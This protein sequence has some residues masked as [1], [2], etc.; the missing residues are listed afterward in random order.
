MSLPPD[1][2]HWEH[3]QDMI[4]REHNKGV[5]RY[6]KDLGDATWEPSVNT[7]R[8]AIRT[9]CTVD[10]KDTVI[11]TLLRLYLFYDI[12]G[13]GKK[14]LGRV[15]GVPDHRIEEDVAG[16][17]QVFLYFSQDK[18]SVP[19]GEKFTDAEYSFRLMNETSSSMTEN[20]AKAIAR[21]IKQE[22]IVS[23]KGWSFTKGKYI[24]NYKDPSLGYRLGIRASNALEGEGV[25][26]KILSIQNHAFD[27]NKLTINEPKK[28]SQNNPTQTKLIYG[29]QKKVNRWRP[30][31]NVR[32][33]YAYMYVH[34]LD[35]VVYLADTTGNFIDVLED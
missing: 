17:P 13:Y 22:F 6:F 11:Q 35:N 10:D 23:N 25:I 2:G 15:F 28:N 19:D 9:A 12:L 31:A 29:Q 1:F 7:P 21:Q 4:R 26:R 5:A 34:G 30:T 33:R 16:K 24:V 27:E 32:F 18:Q 20:K 14:G 3:L 8:E